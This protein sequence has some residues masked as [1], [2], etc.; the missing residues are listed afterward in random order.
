MRKRNRT[1]LREKVTE[2]I[3]L[4]K[5]VALSMPKI[6]VLAEKEANIEN[7]KGIIALGREEIRL[8]TAAGIVCLYGENLDVSAITD[9]DISIIGSIRKIEL[10]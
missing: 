2:A 7:Y 1:P 10:E 9:E 8:Y 5:E 6:T 3:E 4:P